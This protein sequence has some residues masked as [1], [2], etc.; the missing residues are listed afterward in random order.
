M[1]DQPRR[2]PEHFDLD[3]YL[4]AGGFEYPEGEPIPLVALFQRGAARHLQETPLSDDQRIVDEDDW[5]V[6]LTATVNDT[7][8]LRWWLLG[9]GSG[10]EVLE[11]SGA[12]RGNG[13][14]RPADG[15]ALSVSVRDGWRVSR[16]GHDDSSEDGAAARA[17]RCRRSSELPCRCTSSRWPR[18]TSLAWPSWRDSVTTVPG[19]RR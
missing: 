16:P 8:L 2:L 9:F 3:A 4:R 11:P 19:A 10:V 18:R 7:A 13:R 17:S 5:R 6:R 14:N 15:L 12:A 1:L